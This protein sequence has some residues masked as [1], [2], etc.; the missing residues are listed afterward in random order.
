MNR[1]PTA[2]TSCTFYD[3]M[4]DNRSGTLTFLNWMKALLL[5]PG[6]LFTAGYL[7]IYLLT[8]LYLDNGIRPKLTEAV[9][10]AT[11][12]TWN[13]SFE[14]ISSGPAMKSVTINRLTIVP[15]LPPAT[16]TQQGSGIIS[17]TELRVPCS[18]LGTILFDRAH[19]DQ[20][21]LDI[22]RRILVSLTASVPNGSPGTGTQ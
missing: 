15:A 3:P 11:D 16:D 5:S 18:H 9:S 6:I 8:N 20:S 1:I 22:S 17:I 7:T 19:A 14:S 13:L 2:E 10:R 4:Q 12:D 21:A